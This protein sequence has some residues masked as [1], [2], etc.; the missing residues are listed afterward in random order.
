MQVRDAPRM[1]DHRGMP[2]DI[3]TNLV[4][5]DGQIPPLLRTGHYGFQ[6]PGQLRRPDTAEGRLL[7]LVLGSSQ[8]MKTAWIEDLLSLIPPIAFLLA[9]RFN[10]RGPT[11]RF[12]YGFHRTVSIAY[13]CSALA[14][15]LM[16]TYL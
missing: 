12:P 15:F 1:G 5:Q 6:P 16:G 4:E 2:H 3:L 13:L 9:V 7:V 14:L 10:T 11:R 8:A